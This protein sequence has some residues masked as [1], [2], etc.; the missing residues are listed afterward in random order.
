MLTKENV[1]PGL[2]PVCRTILAGTLARYVAI[3]PPRGG[4]KLL[5]INNAKELATEWQ[6]KY[7]NERPHT[8]IGGA[9][10]RRL[11]MTA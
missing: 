5:A 9:P 7:N 1:I 3:W 4:S 8:G 11:L 10:P 6:W 2:I